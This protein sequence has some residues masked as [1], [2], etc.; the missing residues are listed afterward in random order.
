MWIL[1]FNEKIL[2]YLLILCTWIISSACMSMCHVYA[3]LVP[4][5]VRRSVGIPG[6]GVTDG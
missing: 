2:I 4:S 3:F 1:A 5:E 6:P